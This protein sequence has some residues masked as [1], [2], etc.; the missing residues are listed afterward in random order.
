MF[1]RRILFSMLL[2][3]TLVFPGCSDHMEI[4]RISFPLAMGIDYDKTNNKIIVYAQIST[5]HSNQDGQ[6]QT[7]KSYKV[8]DGQGDTLLDAIAD[9]TSKGAQSISWK[10]ITVVVMTNEMAKHGIENE[11]DLL[12]RFHQIHMNSYFMLTNEDLKEL[13]ESTPKIETSLPTPLAGIRLVSMQSSHTK[14]ITIREFAIAYL[15]EGREP[16]IP[17]VSIIKGDEEEITIDYPGLGVFQ[18]NKLV[19]DLDEDASRGA[20]LAYGGK[21]ISRIL[22][23]APKDGNHKDFTIRSIRS[24]PEIIP[25]LHQ[26]MPG[27]TIKL[28]ITY[29]LAQNS[30]PAKLD[31]EKN[32]WINSQIEAYIKNNVEATLYKIQKELKS[33]IF[34]FGEEIY[35][36]YPKYWEDS[37]YKWKEIFPD[38]PINVEV[39]ANLKNTGELI[40]G[41]GFSIGED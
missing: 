12:C 2:L 6:K 35:R 37:K 21:N 34:G 28:D 16:V 25:Y 24:S 22:I 3:S 40:N 11:L 14:A 9:I 31:T 38:I 20:V 15:S 23:P 41:L 32:D 29:T 36:K 33:D 5:V 27:I 17:K 39:K 26:N 13:L 18:K 4:D 8:L 1:V 19:G 10:H 7:V 30:I